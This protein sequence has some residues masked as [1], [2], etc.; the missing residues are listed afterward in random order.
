LGFEDVN[1]NSD[2][3]FALAKQIKSLER[4]IKTKKSHDLIELM[5]EKMAQLIEY[6]SKYRVDHKHMLLEYDRVYN[7]A[8][9]AI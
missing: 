1:F 6:C 8:Y 2:K 9:Q 3:A 4:N 5:N 7:Y